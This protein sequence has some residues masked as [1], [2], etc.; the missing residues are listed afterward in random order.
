MTIAAIDPKSRVLLSDPPISTLIG[1]LVDFDPATHAKI[2][3]LPKAW[4]TALD[5]PTDMVRPAIS[6]IRVYQRSFTSPHQVNL[7]P[8]TSCNKQGAALIIVLAFVVILSGL[9]VAYLSRTSTDR[10][11][12]HDTFSENRAD[13]MARSAVDLVVGDLK[14]EIVNGST[15]S[16]VNG[17]TIYTPSSN[18][19]M[20]RTCSG[21]PSPARTASSN[22]VR[23]SIRSDPVPTLLEFPAA[24]LRLTRRAMFH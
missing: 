5:G 6:G 17:Y 15:V 4:Q 18:A 23:R 10:Q 21:T 3:D 22:M 16:T 2:G 11:L 24:R 19:N 8:R 9:A 12:A 14:Q 1:R 13:L 20:V 7:T